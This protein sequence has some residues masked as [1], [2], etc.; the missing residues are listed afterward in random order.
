MPN[1]EPTSTA[2]TE[3]SEGCL[4]EI[5]KHQNG[6]TGRHIVKFKDGALKSAFLAGLQSGGANITIT[7]EWDIIN[8]IAGKNTCRLSF[9]GITEH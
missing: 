9:H 6:T 2:A 1:P 3:P 8:A 4:H 5:R 7:H